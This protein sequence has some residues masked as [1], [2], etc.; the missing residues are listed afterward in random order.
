[1]GLTEDEV[2][3]APE[4]A[5]ISSEQGEQGEEGARKGRPASSAR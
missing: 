3:P 5:A 2:A 4:L 1:M